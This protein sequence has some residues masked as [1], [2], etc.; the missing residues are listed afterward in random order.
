V[1]L[2]SELSAK[3]RTFR[4]GEAKVHLECELA[5]M[6][7]DR[8]AHIALGRIIHAHVDPS[9]LREGRVDPR[10]LDPACR[11][12]GSAYAALGAFTNLARAM[13]KPRS[14]VMKDQRGILATVLQRYDNQHGSKV[15]RD[16]LIVSRQERLRL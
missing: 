16:L 6:V 8:N 14:R 13:A 12:S 10:L 15:D 3:V 5:Q 9:A 7:S 1:G 4:V 11:L 2:T